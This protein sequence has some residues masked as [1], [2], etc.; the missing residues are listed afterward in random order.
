MSRRWALAAWALLLLGGCGESPSPPP[1][2]GRLQ[3]D[4][5]GL[6][7][8]VDGKVTVRGPA[9]YVREL[10]QSTT[11]TGLARGDYE[12]W[13]NPARTDSATWSPNDVTVRVTI[14]PSDAAT[15]TVP[16]TLA[17]GRLAVLL[18]GLPPGTQGRA[19]VAG[20]DRFSVVLTES[21]TLGN[22]VPGS[23]EISTADVTQ[24]TDVYAPNTTRATVNV[25]P[26]LTPAAV[27]LTFT[28][29]S[30]AVSLSIVGLPTA[31]PASVHLTG[32]NGFAQD[33]TASRTVG[34]LLAGLYTVTA[35]TVTSGASRWAPIPASQ[36]LTLAT[37]SSGSATVNYTLVSPGATANLTIA[38]AHF[39]QVVQTFG[40]AVPLVA[41]RDALLRVFVVGS[42]TGIT[43]PDVRVRFYNG[44]TLVSTVTIPPPTPT[45]PTTVDEG[46][47]SASWNYRVAGSLIQPGLS[48]QV[49]VDPAN[50]VP[51]SSESDNSWPDAASPLALQVRTVPPLAVRFVPIT[52]AASGLTGRV[53]TGNLDQFLIGAR[54]LLP[55]ATVSGVI[56]PPFTTNAP[57]VVPSDSNGAWLQILSEINALRS[58]EGGSGIY[59]GILQVPYTSGIA[60]MA[61]ISGRAALG[62]DWFPSASVVVA[63]EIGHS[64]GRFHS[65]CGSAGGVDV[66]YPYPRAAIGV[67]GYDALAGGLVA[68]TASDVMSYCAP[69]WI[70]DYTFNGM[71]NYWLANAGSL[72]ASASVAPRPG[73]LVWGRIQHGRPVLEPAFDV[74]APPSL[75]TRPGAERVELVGESGQ[76]LASL[77][78]S[79][80]RVVD[81]QDSTAAHFAFVVPR[82]MLGAAAL[83]SLRLHA[84]GRIGTM[85][86]AAARATTPE[87]VRGARSGGDAVRLSWSGGRTRAA[88]VRDAATGSVLGIVREGAG[89]VQTSS[90]RL[91]VIVSD[92]VRSERQLIDVGPGAAGRNRQPRK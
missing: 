2:S 21:D 45:A 31:V 43:A 81:G 42:T 5:V 11:L 87:R 10:T 82:D 74:V 15:A 65:P 89:I 32:P 28:L 16:Y 44:A 78:F 75:P 1:A 47:L 34:G 71:L 55:P 83:A 58:A 73:V 23:Y 59:F 56:A 64:M 26:S 36:N 76:V 4:L 20:P 17:T 54:K 92:G 60:G 63:H 35:D 46:A 33:V 27:P 61:Y 41:G 53:S 79:A 86:G 7:A 80:E 85:S 30:G 50:Q 90:P 38:G 48:V 69:V 39:Q 24:G 88:L 49:D 84:R 6:P 68:P 22:L 37:G 51:E 25:A 14:G 57:A 29:I 18:Q 13:P 40:G 62:W 70:S 12:L 91:E 67:Y 72:V 8:G 9:S 66:S 3:V 19:T 77:S 52:Q